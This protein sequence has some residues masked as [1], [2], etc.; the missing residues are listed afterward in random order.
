[1][2]EDEA[3][4]LEKP[5][6]EDE[7]YEVV[8]A[9][10]GDKVPGPNG[11]TMACFQT[12]WDILNGSYFKSKHAINNIRKRIHPRGLSTNQMVCTTGLAPIF[13]QEQT[14]M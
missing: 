1:M 4:W 10:N 5:F 6:G 13:A 2:G 8:E 9:L 7:V 14:A 12:C 11:F 3:I